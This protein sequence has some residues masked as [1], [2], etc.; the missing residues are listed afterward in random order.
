MSFCIV[1]ISEM[2]DQGHAKGDRAIFICQAT[3][4]PISNITHWYFN[5]T[6]I[7]KSDKYQPSTDQ[8]N[9]ATITNTLTVMSVEPSDVG[10]YTCNVSNGRSAD[11][12]SAVLSVYGRYLTQWFV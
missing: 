8:L 2:M 6:P 10:T 5:G 12:S 7:N 3:S 4:E 9:Y 11:T 1:V